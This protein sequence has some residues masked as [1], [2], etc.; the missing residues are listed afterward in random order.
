MSGFSLRNYR[1]I[2]DDVHQA[3]SW[4]ESIG[5]QTNGTRLDMIEQTV[6]GLVSDFDSSLPPAQIV[7]KWSN[8]QTYY[9]LSDG[10]A[11]G[12]IAREIAKVGPNSRPVRS[13]RTLIE[14][15]LS[16]QDE[17]LGDGSVNARNVFAELELA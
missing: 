16:P 7:Q 12:K 10:A 5:I 4:C 17:M 1:E 3:R 6:R 15:P 9:A 2:L 8:A 14:G 13:L 11:F